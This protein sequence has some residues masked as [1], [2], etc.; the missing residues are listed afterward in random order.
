MQEQT[1]CCKRHLKDN[2]L[3]ENELKRIKQKSNSTTL[4]EKEIFDLL[5]SVYWQKEKH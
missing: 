5:Q 1:R 4:S 3:K 2:I